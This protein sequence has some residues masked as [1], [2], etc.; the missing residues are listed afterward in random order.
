MLPHRCYL[1]N[2]FTATPRLVCVWISGYYSLAK[3]T[4]TANHHIVN[5]WMNKWLNGW[6]EMS[7]QASGSLRRTRGVCRDWDLGSGNSSVPQSEWISF[8]DF[9]LHIV[10]VMIRFRKFH[11]I[12]LDGDWVR[13]LP[14]LIDISTKTAVRETGLFSNRESRC[15]SKRRRKILDM[16]K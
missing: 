11:L 16:Q 7:L 1:H 2:T 12:G 6:A 9:Y 8:K 3:L 4:Y 5:K 10:L 14:T 15:C 13:C